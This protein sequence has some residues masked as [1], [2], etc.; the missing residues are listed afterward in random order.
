MEE[1]ELVVRGPV[2]SGNYASVWVA[3]HAWGPSTAYRDDAAGVDAH[4]WPTAAGLGA[5]GE[6]AG[7]PY[8]A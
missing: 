5:V 3:P 7:G 4:R 2:C 6:D 1:E 8:G